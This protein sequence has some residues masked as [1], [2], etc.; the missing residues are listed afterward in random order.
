[1]AWVFL[2]TYKP[3]TDIYDILRKGQNV[4]K[5]APHTTDL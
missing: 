5:T 2:S 3:N 4:T 1:M